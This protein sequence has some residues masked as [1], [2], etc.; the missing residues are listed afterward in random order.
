M[1][2]LIIQ[3]KSKEHI[4]ILFELAILLGDKP[5]IERK[6]IKRKLSKVESEF[7]DSLKNVKLIKKGKLKPN[8]LTDLLKSKV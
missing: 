5:T 4:K 2:T 8:R 6:A 1:E 3:S 7:A